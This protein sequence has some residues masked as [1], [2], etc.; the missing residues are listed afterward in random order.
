MDFVFINQ[1]AHNKNTNK[2]P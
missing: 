1:F 2:C